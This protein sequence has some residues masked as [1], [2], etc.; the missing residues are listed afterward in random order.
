VQKS[1][2]NSE[3]KALKFNS[4]GV[5]LTNIQTSTNEGMQPLK[6][7]HATFKAAYIAKEDN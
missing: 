4:C 6:I 3:V 5:N 7:K 2:R 1:A